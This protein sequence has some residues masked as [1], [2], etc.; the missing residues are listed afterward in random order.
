MPTIDLQLTSR[1]KL[2]DSYFSIEGKVALIVY[3]LRNKLN[4]I[5]GYRVLIEGKEMFCKA[6]VAHNHFKLVGIRTD[7]SRGSSKV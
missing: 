4:Q 3:V 1:P 2:I 5:T 6:K 7:E